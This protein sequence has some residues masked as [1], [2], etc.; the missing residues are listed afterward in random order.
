MADYS[1]KDIADALQYVP[2]D[3]PP[4]QKAAAV[5]ARLEPGFV[6]K[7]WDTVNRPIAGTPDA[8]VPALRHTHSED[9]S[10][11]RKV[12]E[13]LAASQSSPFNLGLLATGVGAGLAGQAG[14]LGISN[15]ARLAEGALQ[16]PL[17]AE[18]AYHALK[19]DASVGER[20]GGAVEGALGAHGMTSAA[21][22]AFDP[23]AV[24]ATYMKERGLAPQERVPYNP[25]AAK[26][27]ADRYEASG[28]HLRNAEGVIPSKGQTGYVPL[29][30]RPFAKQKAGLLSSVPPSDVPQPTSPGS[31]S[32]ATTPLATLQHRSS[33]GGLTELDPAKY[34]TGQPGAELRRQASYPQDFVGR[35]YFTRE[36]GF[37]EPRFQKLPHVYETSLPESHLYDMGKDPGGFGPIASAQAG[38]DNARAMTLAEKAVKDAGYKG[39]YNSTSS[40]PDAVALFHKT[41]VSAN[42][43]SDF[44]SPN[45]QRM[46]ASKLT[47]DQFGELNSF[48]EKTPGVTSAQASQQLKLPPNKRNISNFEVVDEPSSVNGSGESAASQEA[49]NRQ[50]SMAKQGQHFAVQKGGVTRSL[51]GPDAVDYQPTKGETY[52][53]VEKDGRFRPLSTAMAVASPVASASIDDS[54]PNDPHQQLKHYAKLG[55]DLAGIAG[56]GAAVRANI[57]SPQK[58]AAAKGAA[59]M[60]LGGTKG[61]WAKRMASEGIAAADVPKV[62]SASEKILAQQV[63][64]S[65]TGLT[66][67]KSLVKMFTEGQA[68]GD[69]YNSG[70][71]LTKHFGK[72]APMVANLIAATSNNSTVKSN[73]T[74]ALKV[75]AQHKAN[76]DL[77][78]EGIMKTLLPAISKATAGEELGGRKVNN[79][80]KA[81]LGDPN[82]VVVDRWMMR[83]FGFKGDVP[84][85]TQ[86]DVIEHG[87][88]E[89]AKSQGVTPREA[90]AALWFGA[91]KKLEGSGRPESPPYGALLKGL[92][93]DDVNAQDA[94][95]GALQ[96]WKAQPKK[97]FGDQLR[98]E[99]KTRRNA[100]P[101]E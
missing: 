24:M 17:V 83:A 59:W 40:L 50:Q 5:K 74:L 67:V 14:K 28:A 6:E 49:I 32:S 92:F 13:D 58:T 72:D 89:M 101:L 21:A 60:M 27:I 45:I 47:K 56:F 66:H 1:L 79:F 78:I 11:P 76:P 86:Y 9:E 51:I 77:P 37:V 98:T 96:R 42:P 46:D 4:E 36:G 62:R 3:L 22:H 10:V 23:K 69:W 41:P 31:P 73:L 48:M 61:D 35:T 15:A 43:L 63:A 54:D 55:L 65:E 70:D 87:I 75:Y 30:E 7:A 85:P 68:E 52:G 94:L 19:P 12:V 16:A 2:A 8:L 95:Q 84:T 97:G 90:Q 99:V 39:Y 18:G 88:Q 93:G 81:L 64:K 100:L 80:A 20:L 25:E 26:G 29:S 44:A 91:K 38:L 71:E 82:A 34:G 57:Q 33:I 53:V